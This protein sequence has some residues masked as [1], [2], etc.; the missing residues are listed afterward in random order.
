MKDENGSRTPKNGKQRAAEEIINTYNRNNPD[1]PMAIASLRYPS[2]PRSV[3]LQLFD[4]IIFKNPLNGSLFKGWVVGMKLDLSSAPHPITWRRIS[5]HR[6]PFEMGMKEI[7]EKT[8]NPFPVE[9][10]F[11]PFDKSKPLPGVLGE[12]DAYVTDFPDVPALAPELLTP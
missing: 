3:R 9:F 8:A 10:G 1:K 11:F 4:L 7:I 12:F 5:V 2:T 6:C